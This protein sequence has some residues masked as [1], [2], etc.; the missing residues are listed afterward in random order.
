[1]VWS[2]DLTHVSHQ[3]V[4]RTH[5]YHF[6]QCYIEMGLTVDTAQS[7]IGIGVDSGHGSTS[8]ELLFLIMCIGI[9]D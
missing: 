1:M 3:N 6:G 9:F 7:Y 5:K 2:V 8:A 4:S